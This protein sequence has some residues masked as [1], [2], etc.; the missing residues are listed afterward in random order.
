MNTTA[1]RSRKTQRGQTIRQIRRLKDVTQER[2]GHLVGVS[3]S[4]ISRMEAGELP[5]SPEMCSR[6]LAALESVG[7]EMAGR[8]S[9]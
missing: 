1:N 8:E 7:Q 6:L 4:A 5:V 9:D 3:Q 2:L